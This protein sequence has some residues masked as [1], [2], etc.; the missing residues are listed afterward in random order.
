MYPRNALG[1]EG[2]CDR[3]LHR[4]T[5]DG[6]VVPRRGAS[7]TGNLEVPGYRAISCTGRLLLLVFEFVAAQGQRVKNTGEKK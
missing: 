2:R 1:F 5:T 7:S 6:V 3:N 4:D